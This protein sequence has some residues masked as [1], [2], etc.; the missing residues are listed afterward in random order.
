MNLDNNKNTYY[1]SIAIYGDLL[2]MLFIN[3]MNYYLTGII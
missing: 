1:Y 2:E 3:F